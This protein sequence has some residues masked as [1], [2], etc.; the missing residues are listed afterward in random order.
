MSLLYD[1][2]RVTNDTYFYK[3]NHQGST[4]ELSKY[5]D[6]EVRIH[7]ENN[8]FKEVEYPFKGPY[9]RRVWEVLKYIVAEIERIEKELNPIAGLHE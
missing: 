5:N 1:K 6:A 7:F 3:I 8:E 9:S 2:K 4:D